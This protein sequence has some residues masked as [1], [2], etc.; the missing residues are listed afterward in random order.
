M[1]LARQ[2]DPSCGR[3]ESVDDDEDED[4]VEVDDDA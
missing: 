2:H 1:K 4:E 3:A